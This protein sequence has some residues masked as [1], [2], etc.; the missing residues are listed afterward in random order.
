[1]FTTNLL[2]FT[3][4]GDKDFGDINTASLPDTHPGD[5]G[6]PGNL[7][8]MYIVFSVDKWKDTDEKAN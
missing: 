7:K 3:I 8:Q 4:L 1:M 6:V 5:L 2:L